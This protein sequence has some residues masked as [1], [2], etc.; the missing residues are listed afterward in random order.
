MRS[1]WKKMVVLILALTMLAGCSKGYPGSR[2]ERELTD[3]LFRE[4]LDNMAQMDAMQAYYLEGL[5]ACYQYVS[6][7]LD[8][9]SWKDALDAAA[10]K[11]SQHTG[12]PISQ[13]LLDACQDSPFSPTELQV[14]PELVTVYLRQTPDR[15]SFLQEFIELNVEVEPL[16][17][18]LL[19]DLYQEISQEELQ[20]FWYASIEFF[21]PITEKSV[22]NTFCED[23][24]ALSG[25]QK[26]AW[27]VPAT[28]SEAVRLRDNHI[29]K[30]EKLLDQVALVSGQ[31][32]GDINDYHE[33]LMQVLV[34]ELGLSQERAQAY[35][36][37]LQRIASKEQLLEMRKQELA[38]KEQEL[39]SLREQ[40]RTKFAPLPE[41]EPGILWGKAK[42][43][44]SVGMYEEAAMCLQVLK[45][46]E[47]SDFLPECCDAGIVFY[48]N[49]PQMGYA[50]G[51]IVLSPPPEGDLEP[52]QVGDVLVS[53]E[54]EPVYTAETYS[55]LRET[56]PEGY[57]AQIL[58]QSPQGTMELMD[59]TVPPGVRFY[60]IDLV[61]NA[62][63]KAQ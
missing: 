31:I 27:D 17:C 13:E 39:E 23:V 9:A 61:K 20:A 15:L 54:G 58:R 12:V 5:D 8:A 11:L 25:F 50:Y 57:Q 37:T 55:A 33:E 52:Y 30:M 6:G 28:K 10:Q 3:R 42:H 60:Y 41:D 26:I 1:C 46:Q 48:R 47:D 36:E 62:G 16:Y 53:V 22:L 56:Y 45:E 34:E 18:K 29:R 19:L 4:V 7:E 38:E 40:M 14:L 32:Q 35:I 49:A 24:C 51:V 44:S 43:F 59:L 21:L 2:K 63:Q